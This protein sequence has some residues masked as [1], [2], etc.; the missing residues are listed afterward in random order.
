MSDKLNPK[1]R[2]PKAS[3]RDVSRSSPAFIDPRNT[4]ASCT[5]TG[6]RPQGK[7]LMSL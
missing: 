5:G 7:T 4:S 1:T 3:S 2:S 6:H